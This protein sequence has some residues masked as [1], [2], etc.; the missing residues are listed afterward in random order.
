MKKNS[1]KK[2]VVSR[3]KT[4]AQK[5]IYEQRGLNFGRP[6]MLEWVKKEMKKDTDWG[7][8]HIMLALGALHVYEEK[9][10]LDKKLKAEKRS[11]IR[12]AKQLQPSVS[13]SDYYKHSYYQTGKTH[14]R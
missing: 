11:L 10:G 6:G 12:F 4:E 1:S 8:R 3:G 2:E 5:S 9:Y 13:P 14:I 7:Y